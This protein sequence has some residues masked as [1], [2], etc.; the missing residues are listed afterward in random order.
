MNTVHA[1]GTV[2]TPDPRHGDALAGVRGTVRTPDPRHGD[3]LA[4]VRPDHL[5]AHAVRTLPA[6]T[7][8]PL[9]GTLAHRLA[10]RLARRGSG[11]GVATLHA[12]VGQGPA[13]VLER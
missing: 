4:G 2:R 12:G 9:A 3:A 8:A 5:A 11:T 7:P 10:R 6:R 13:P 1:V